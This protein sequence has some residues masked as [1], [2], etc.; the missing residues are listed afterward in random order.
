MQEG[1]AP[2]TV[3]RR[4]IEPVPGRR[5]SID[6][7]V[8]PDLRAI[9]HG[10]APGPRSA[11]MLER[12]AVALASWQPRPEDDDAARERIRTARELR[13]GERSLDGG[14][15]LVEREAAERT[16]DEDVDQI[17]AAERLARRIAASG[18]PK[19][20]D[21]G[22][23]HAAAIGASA[24]VPWRTDVIWMGD[25]SGPST[26]SPFQPSAP[27]R[28]PGAMAQLERF[29]AGDA[30]AIGR[31][32][33]AFAQLPVIHP[34]P[35]GNGRAGRLLG[36]TVLAASLEHGGA[37]P[38][39]SD[40]IARSFHAAQH[41]LTAWWIEDDLDSW[42]AMYAGAVLQCCEADAEPRTR[43]RLLRRRTSS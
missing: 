26:E 8:P 22:A 35:D 9:D 27:E 30:D 43:R 15:P 37:G 39:V 11:P 12:A 38:H 41:G 31:A 1:K 6:L 16:S 10:A 28:I 13:R 23:L 34:W 14:A 5:V 3:D 36:D 24:A 19:L 2:M 33:V 25:R 17:L 4:T 29:L 21:I 32:A 18:Q 42:V 7:L 40:R 20:D